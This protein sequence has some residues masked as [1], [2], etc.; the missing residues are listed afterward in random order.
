MTRRVDID[1]HAFVAYNEYISDSELIVAIDP[2]HGGIL[3]GIYQTAPNKM[4]THEWGAFYEGVFNRAI[5]LTLS[6]M[7]LEEGIS[8]YFTTDSNVDVS[9]PVRVTR[10]NNYLKRFPD[11]RHLFLSIHGNAHS[12]ESANGIEVWT[13]PEQTLSDE[14]A[15]IFFNELKYMKWKMRSDSSDGDPDKESRFYVLVKTIMPSVLLE[16]GFYSNPEEAVKMNTPKYQQQISDKIRK[17]I[18][19]IQD[20]EKAKV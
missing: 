17:G 2:G 7:L 11:K 14:Y 3:D 20:Y 16:L 15:T 1:K 13:S 19:K 12:N 4:Y 9:L 8:H 6:G 18:L 5:S 10:A